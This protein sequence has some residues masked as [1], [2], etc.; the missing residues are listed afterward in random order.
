MDIYWLSQIK[1]SERHLVGDRPW[2]LSQLLQHGCPI[3]PGFVLDHSLFTEVLKSLKVDECSLGSLPDS[4]LLN[5]N[6]YRALQSIAQRSR[7]LIREVHLPSSWQEQIFAAAQQLNSPTLILQPYITIPG[8]QQIGNWSLWRSHTCFTNPEAIANALKKVWGE[9]FAAKSLCYWHKLGLAIEQTNLAILIQS[10]K[11]ARASGIIEVG[12]QVITIQATWGLLPSLWRGEIKPDKYQINRKRKT[13]LNKQ[14]GHHSLEYRLSDRSETANLSEC[15]ES[16]LIDDRASPTYVLNDVEITKL[17]E[18]TTF[19]LEHQSSIKYLEWTLPQ[20]EASSDINREEAAKVPV[21]LDIQSETLEEDRLEN[22]LN[23]PKFYFTQFNY[24][25]APSIDA[26]NIIT[27]SN[28]LSPNVE[29]LLTGLAAAPGQ[30]EAVAVVIRD[31]KTNTQ[32]IVPDCILVTH[33]VAPQQIHL[34]NQVAGIITETGG[35]TSHGAIMAR[36]LKIPAIV[37]AV[38][39]TQILRPQE[40]IFLDGSRG[41]V[42]RA[43]DMQPVS[44]HTST[45]PKLHYPIATKLMVNISQPSSIAEAVDLPVDGVGLLRSELMLAELLNSQTKASWR[46]EA[47][48]SLLLNTLINLLRQ[49]VSAFAPRPVFYRSIDWYAHDEHQ[50]SLVGERGTYSYLS[51]AT[52]FD[53]ELEAIATILAEGYSNLNLILPFVRS[54]EEFKFCR[55]RLADKGITG[56]PLFK[57]WIMAEVP[58]VIFLLPEYIKAG[59]QG[60]AIGTNDLTQLLLGVNREQS[61]FSSRGLSVRHPALAKAIAQLITTARTYNIPCSICGQAPVEYPDLIERLVE[62]GITS[63]SVDTEAIPEIYRAIARAEKRLLLKKT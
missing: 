36:E 52:L 43:V 60:I 20:I 38:N 46:Q 28:Y 54:I 44:T 56:Y 51:D 17:T 39:A 8:V 15:L 34:L 1:H 19:L 12:R 45:L 41:K 59:V 42:Y 6:D 9:L 10:L 49:F 21:N 2:I 18:L 11:P 29:P 50:N 23:K 61:H 47:S 63:I 37:N 7:N 26:N 33:S 5:V 32:K 48:R 40:K 14:R 24:R 4:S 57:L 16:H 25:P 31:L 55:R 35:V 13:I 3:M 53:L 58:S 30:M 62:W 22:I 27:S